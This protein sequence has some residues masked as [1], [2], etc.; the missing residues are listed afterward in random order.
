MTDDEIKR[1]VDQCERMQLDQDSVFPNCSA[2]SDEFRAALAAP[3]PSADDEMESAQRIQ[4]A[5]QRPP[6][7]KVQALYDKLVSIHTRH[8]DGEVSKEYFA[9]G[10][11]AGQRSITDAPTLAAPSP[12][13]S[14]VPVASDDMPPP[15]KDHQRSHAHSFYMSLPH[16]WESGEAIIRKVAADAYVNGF[17]AG[18]ACAAPANLAPSEDAKDA[19][20]YRWLRQQRFEFNHSR[21]TP[22]RPDKLDSMI[23][24]ALLQA[25][26]ATK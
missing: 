8:E 2:V 3:S 16:S 11:I 24:S 18:K 23:D 6:S 5:V 25:N 13:A 14:S 9:L 19:A 20:R 10:F 1:V 26:G 12:S 7:A 22:V 4:R 17:Q 15:L 21:V